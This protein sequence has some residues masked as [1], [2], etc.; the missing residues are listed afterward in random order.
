MMDSEISNK[1]TPGGPHVN[2]FWRNMNVF[3]LSATFD[4]ETYSSVHG[5]QMTI[6]RPLY[7]NSFRRKGHMFLV[8]Q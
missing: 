6:V 2:P 8:S 7:L 1:M 3:D 4:L 5:S